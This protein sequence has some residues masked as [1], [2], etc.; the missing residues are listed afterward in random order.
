MDNLVLNNW[1]L[2]NI[3]HLNLA[4]RICGENNILYSL[5]RV[6]IIM[7]V[8][9]III[10]TTTITTTTTTSITTTVPINIPTNFHHFNNDHHYS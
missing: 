2:I 6:I 1:I 9:I 5:K 10:I 8:I 4:S 3:P 7:I